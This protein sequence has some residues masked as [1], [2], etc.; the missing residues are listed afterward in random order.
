MAVKNQTHS[1]VFTSPLNDIKRNGRKRALS[2]SPS[3][4]PL[5][6]LPLL[7][8]SSTSLTLKRSIAF[9]ATD[10]SISHSTPTNY[11]PSPS[12]PPPPH[13]GSEAALCNTERRSATGSETLFQ[14]PH[15]HPHAD[16]RRRGTSTQLRLPWKWTEGEEGYLHGMSALENNRS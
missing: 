11:A 7:S 2:H 5:S 14:F 10:F 6:P 9:D 4:F 15:T 1:H 3:P 12:L 16:R 8:L 13:D